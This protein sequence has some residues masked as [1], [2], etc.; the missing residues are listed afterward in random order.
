MGWVARVKETARE[1]KIEALAMY[2]AVRHPWTPWSAR[3][4]LVFILLYAASPIDI[5]PDFIPVLGMLDDIVVIAAG[6]WL[7]RRLIP[8]AV[9]EECREKA[10]NV[11]R[12]GGLIRSL[13]K[14]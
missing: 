5:I 7:A 14:D 11:D 2:Y 4:V 8:D 10:R 9:M 6:L 13:F 12:E 1:L 3:L